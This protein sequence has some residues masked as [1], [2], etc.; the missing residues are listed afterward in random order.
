MLEATFSAGQNPGL[1]DLLGKKVNAHRSGL[2]DMFR[3]M[4]HFA[5]WRFA[6]RYPVHVHPPAMLS[7]VTEYDNLTRMLRTSAI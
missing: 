5:V 6:T 2:P 4:K 7:D 1:W 3:Q